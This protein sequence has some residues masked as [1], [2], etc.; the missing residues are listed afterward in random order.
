MQEQQQLG[1]G[2][3]GGVGREQPVELVGLA[4]DL[5]AMKGYA[6]DIVA[7][8]ALGAA[9]GDDAEAFGLDEFDPAGIGKGFFGG[10]DDLDQRTMG[11]GGRKP[12]E[13]RS[14]LGHMRAESTTH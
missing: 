13:A 14:D 12:L 7:G 10:I 3:A 8:P 4:A 2:T 6:R 9:R 11:A 1:G 5:V